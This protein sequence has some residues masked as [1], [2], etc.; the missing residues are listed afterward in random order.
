MGGDLQGI[1][2]EEVQLNAREVVVLSLVVDCPCLG[3]PNQSP[4]PSFH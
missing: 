2:I 1:E 3:R 4:F